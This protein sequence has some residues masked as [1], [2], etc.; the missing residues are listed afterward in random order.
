MVAEGDEGGEDLR[1][2]FLESW[3]TLKLPSG[4]DTKGTAFKKL[5]ATEAA[6]PIQHFLSN[7]DCRR[8]FISGKV[9][10]L[11]FR[12]IYYFFALTRSICATQDK[13]NKELVCGDLP[14]APLKKKAIYFVKLE[15]QPLTAE[16]V[17]S[18][19]MP[20]DLLPEMLAQ[21][22]TM[23]DGAYLPLMANGE[24]QQGWPP[25]VVGDLVDG[26]SRLTS[27]VY[28]TLGQT[29][30]KTLLP[31]PPETA[32]VKKMQDRQLALDKER[33]HGYEAAVVSWTR[34]IKA[35][36]K[37]DP[38]AG[39]ER[40]GIVT[41]HSGPLHELNFWISRADNLGSIQKQLSSYRIRRVVKVLE[42]THSTYSQAFGRL[43]SDVEN[44]A[45]EANDNVKFLS[46]LREDLD[47][48]ET[49][50]SDAFSELREHFPKIMHRCLLIWAHS[51][52][53]NVPARLAVLIRQMGNA[54]VERAR[55]FVDAEAI[56]DLE[57]QDGLDRLSTALEVCAA[58]KASFFEARDRSA[59]YA[60]DNQWKF[61]N[62]V[63]FA[64]LDLFIERCHDLHEL[65][66]TV[67]Q[68]AK[69]ERIE[70][71]GNKG[72]ALSASIAQMHGDFQVSSQ[73]KRRIQQPSSI[74]Q[75]AARTHL[76]LPHHPPLTHLPPHSPSADD[77]RGLQADLLRLPRHRR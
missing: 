21:M 31:L 17:A 20:G 15:R 67:V 60:P 3:I 58:F 62:A 77:P 46:I 7:P 71:G 55:E 16:N 72:R 43:E 19:V 74:R 63:I 65:Q 38:E 57:P 66:L 24:N 41:S 68:F 30:G 61:Q 44:A 14:P 70:V 8:L 10:A 34:Q 11:L 42:L 37:G 26:L 27:L 49:C 39:T 2:A 28:V 25:Q 69:L 73:A 1:L 56:F 13:E 22:H 54:L 40:N 76:S 52:Y 59:E 29:T 18:L 64:R 36:L 51:R 12:G 48:L 50:A 75:Q 5:L 32:A 35:T 6:A 23:M 45:K 47:L 9:R 33:V 53:Y 4:K